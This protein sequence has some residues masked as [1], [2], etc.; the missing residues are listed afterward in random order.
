MAIIA[1]RVVRAKYAA[2]PYDP[3]DGEGARKSG[4]RWN[5]PGVAM[6]YTT[7]A[8]SLAVLETLVHAEELNS[9]L[10]KRMASFAFDDAD[11][12]V[13]GVAAN[14]PLSLAEYRMIGDTWIAAKT[15][16]VLRVPSVVIPQEFNYLLNPEH[17][18]FPRI[19]PT[20]TKWEPLPIDRR[21]LETKGPP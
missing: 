12:A 5:S 19:R 20:A 21:L 7:W 11:V 16:P 2:P 1:W 6:V 18:D 17:P 10:E 8:I 13:A 3:F 9:L 15:S 4:G 14:K